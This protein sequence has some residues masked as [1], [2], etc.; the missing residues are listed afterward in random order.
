M[1]YVVQHW[2]GAW[3]VLAVWAIVAALH[4]AALRRLPVRRWPRQTAALHGGMLLV[5]LALISPLGY[6]AG[7][8]IWVRSIQDLLL[9][10]A[11]PALIVLGAPREILARRPVRPT[12]WRLAR[13]VAVILAFN[14]IW[15][16]WHVTAAYDLAA[17]NPAVRYLEYVSYLAAGIGFWL[18][19]IGSRPASCPTSRWPGRCCGW[20]FCPR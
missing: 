4:L 17:T 13:P 5:L 18:Q 6:W 20:A 7:R 3:P 11:A 9:A 14:V 12:G 1:S 8:Y 10:F 19:L 2:S 15:L 16:G